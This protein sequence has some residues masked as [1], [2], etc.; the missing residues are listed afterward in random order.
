MPKHQDDFLKWFGSRVR[1]LRHQK[2]LSQEELAELAGIDRT[3]VGGVERGER[4]LSLLNVKRLSDALGI[5]AK[6]LFDDD[7]KL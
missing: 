7:F 3:Y 4:N 1:E 2:N 5:N 6:D